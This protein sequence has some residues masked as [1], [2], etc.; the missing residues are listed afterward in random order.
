MSQTENRL[1]NA[2]GDVKRI[3]HR[4]KRG[5]FQIVFGRTM[6]IV[7]LLAVQVLILFELMASF[8]EYIPYYLG[9]AAAVTA[10]MLIFVLNTRSNPAIKLTWVIVI[11]LLPVF[12]ALLYLYIRNDI[13]HQLEKRLLHAT[14]RESAV[15]IDD[16]SELMDRLRRE[17]KDLYNLASYTEQTCGCPIYENTSVEYFAQGEE[18]FE[19]MLR[20]LEQAKEFI[21]L[22]YFIVQEG[23]MWQSILDVL[24]RKAAEGVEVRVMYDG[25]CALT[26]LPYGYPKQL[27]KMGIRC[28]MF[29]PIRPFVSTHYNNRDH[30]KILIVDGVTAFTGGINIADRYINREQVYGHWKDTAVMLKG[31]AVR[32]LT[33]MF[34]QM[35]NATERKRDYA[36]YLK[37]EMPRVEAEGCV[38]PYGDSPLD[39]ENVGE[40]V[41]LHMLNQAKDYVYIMTPYLILDNE[42]VTALRFAARRG[43]DVR[44]VLPHIPD[45]KYAFLLAKSH[46]AELIGAGVRIYEYTPGFVHAKVFLSDDYHAV[47]GTINLDYRSLYLHFECAAYL[48]R[49]KALREIR[50]DF[51]ETMAVSQEITAEDVK[52]QGFFTRLGGMLLKAAA[53]LM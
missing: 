51:F 48:Y 47:V 3:A 53:P 49:V 19:E 35:W 2:P 26:L 17:D 37:K 44:I 7:L 16:R 39:N 6:V 21:F 8:A 29:S 13:G 20:Q 28:K 24:K 12:G 38:L 23:Y 40:M 4:S 25:T 15:H 36:P 45:K 50:R 1:K 22:E 27:E 32:S 52:K 30:R 43:V 9:S 5:F 10:F 34:L 11:A 42:M 46:Y 18:K 41:Y 14:L 33:L 31:E